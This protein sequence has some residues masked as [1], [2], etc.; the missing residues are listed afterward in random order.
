MIYGTIA[1]AEYRERRKND[2]EKTRK[3]ERFV[4]K[5]YRDNGLKMQRIF[6]YDMQ[7]RGV[8]VIHKIDEETRYI[9]EKFA[10]QYYNRDLNT[11]AFELSS[12]NNVD[13]NGWFTSEHMITTHYCILWFRSDDS[14]KN[15]ES[16]D[17]CYINKKKIMEYLYSVGYRDN[18][19]DEFCNY[20][21]GGID[22]KY[23]RFYYERNG[24]RYRDL[25]NGVRIVQ[26]MQFEVESPI[27]VVIPKKEL[28]KL[29]E[30]H[31]HN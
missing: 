17:L 20:W 21:D 6:D 23:R 19:L 27:N 26:S 10:V 31:F 25:R 18:I 4:D 28:F 14:F 24:R 30:Y 7:T 8:D 5:I 16:Y 12:H 13:D 29:A 22:N 9:D 11:F 3:I 1:D 2:N 15:I